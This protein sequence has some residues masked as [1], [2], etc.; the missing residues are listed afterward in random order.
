MAPI[1][2]SP[3]F[4]A[5]SGDGLVPIGV[6]NLADGSVHPDGQ[7]HFYFNRPGDAKSHDLCPGAA[8]P[9]VTPSRG[10]LVPVHLHRG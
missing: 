2:R 7:V 4:D 8:R 10:G 6:C 9:E 5:T 1:G 3:V